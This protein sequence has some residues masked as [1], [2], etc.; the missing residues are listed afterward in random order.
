MSKLSEQE[1]IRREKREQLK[2]LGINAYP[3]E[4]FPVDFYSTNLPDQYEEGKKVVLAGRLM[5][6]RIQGKASFAELQDSQGKVQVYFNRDEICPSEDKSLYNE[7]YKK[8]LD[9]GDIIGIEGELFTT[10]V[11]EQTVSNPVYPF[12]QNVTTTSFTKN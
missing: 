2:K 7:V 11:G 5:S 9:I 3:A 6:R 4:L 10:M 8:L 1:L 12:K